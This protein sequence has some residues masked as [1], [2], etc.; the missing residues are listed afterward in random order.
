VNVSTFA[1][2]LRHL[3]AN[4]ND[5]V[6]C[7]TILARGKVRGAHRILLLQGR[8]RLGNPAPAVLKA[9]EAVTDLT[10]L[11]GLVVGLP[12]ASSWEELLGLDRSG[13]EVQRTG[14][15]LEPHYSTLWQLVLDL[16]ES[17]TYQAIIKEG[18]LE[19]TWKVLL[20]QGRS[21]FGEPTR[22]EMVT[23]TLAELDR[24]E[25]LATRLLEVSNWQEL[26]GAND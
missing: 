14:I 21:R 17:S 7:R 2:W 5:S 1:R 13:P 12:Q 20:A 15:V 3:G 25:E 24:L 26:F 4:L 16:E 10:Q 22:A 6:I 11:E 23:L 19:E 9:L 18:A 8:S